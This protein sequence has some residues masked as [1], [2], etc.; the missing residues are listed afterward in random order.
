MPEKHF[1]S[2]ELWQNSERKLKDALKD[3]PYAYE[4]GAGAF[5][6]PK[7]DFHIKDS[8]GRA[9]QLGSIQLDYVL[10]ERFDLKYQD[11][12]NHYARPVVIH[13]AAFGS[14]ERFLGI[15]LEHYQGNLPIWL[16][17]NPVVILPISEKQLLYAKEIQNRLPDAL[18]WHKESLKNRIRRAHMEKIPEIWIVGDKEVRQKEVSID[19]KA[20]A[21]EI[22]IENLNHKLK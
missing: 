3:M 8:Q 13:R 22:A 9:W 10:P 14:L 15:L 4:A 6:G 2:K 11:K 7:I 16:A 1:V 17:P 21:L 5:Y 18:V 20:V 12:N 19:H